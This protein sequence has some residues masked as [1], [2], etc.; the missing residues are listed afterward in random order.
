MFL[1]RILV[2]KWNLCPGSI[3]NTV[4]GAS[5]SSAALRVLSTLFFD[6]SL[7]YFF[8]MV[9]GCVLDMNH[10]WLKKIGNLMSL[11]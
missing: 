10:V 9:A 8:L 7:A 11:A 6:V 5:V 2:W 4:F 3:T 1:E